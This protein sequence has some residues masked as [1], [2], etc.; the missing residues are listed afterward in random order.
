MTSIT[1]TTIDRYISY[2]H[3][4]IGVKQ[5][6][7][8]MANLPLSSYQPHGCDLVSRSR[9]PTQWTDSL[10]C[11]Q[12]LLPTRLP[13]EENNGILRLIRVRYSVCGGEER[14]G[15]GGGGGML[16]AFIHLA[17]NMTTP[18]R[19]WNLHCFHA[20][21]TLVYLLLFYTNTSTIATATATCTARVAARSWDM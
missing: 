2:C 14:R 12:P 4:S 18:S 5:Q 9:S 15:G 16:A 8:N 7:D 3:H 6:P 10:A 13:N 17:A 1:S 19:M 20:H 21:Q 11:T